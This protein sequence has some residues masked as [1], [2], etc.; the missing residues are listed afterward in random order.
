MYFL[1]TY[2]FCS[3]AFRSNR[4][5]F[6]TV[7][8]LVIDP[9]LPPEL[10]LVFDAFVVVPP[11][12]PPPPP[13]VRVLCFVSDDA[14]Q[15][16]CPS[17]LPVMPPTPPAMPPAGWWCFCLLLLLLPPPLFSPREERFAGAA[18]SVVCLFRSWEA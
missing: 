14:V 13:P 7:G 10:E 17:A 9:P 2:R 8:A 6:C 11:S 1:R 16:A 18:A 12:P 4:L 3:R 5:L 15:P